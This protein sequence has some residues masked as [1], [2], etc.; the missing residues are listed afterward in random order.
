M[1]E[2]YNGC[3]YSNNGEFLDGPVEAIRSN[4]FKIIRTGAMTKEQATALAFSLEKGA[5]YTVNLKKTGDIANGADP[6]TDTF[7]KID[8]LQAK[9]L[10]ETGGELE[11]LPAT[12]KTLTG[13]KPFRDALKN[14]DG[15]LKDYY[16]EKDFDLRVYISENA[17]YS[18][19]TLFLMIP[20]GTNPYQFIVD[21]GWKET[22]DR[23]SIIVYLLMPS[24]EKIDGVTTAWGS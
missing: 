15:K 3:V 7:T 5:H 17:R 9:K 19:P 4:W 2:T 24:H 16:G 13:Q 21:S 8:D 22:A 10:V 12:G 1:G 20:S 18:Q 14:A 23:N 6:V 11:T